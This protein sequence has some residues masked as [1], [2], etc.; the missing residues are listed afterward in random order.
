M[1]RVGARRVGAAMPKQK[2]AIK[3]EDC[4]RV[5]ARAYPGKF[6][7]NNPGGTSLTRE[8]YK[9]KAVQD[10]VASFKDNEKY[11]NTYLAD[12]T[13][14]LVWH[15]RSLKVNYKEAYKLLV[16]TETEKK[17]DDS[18]EED[19]RGGNEEKGVEC[20]EEEFTETD[21]M[22]ETTDMMEIEGEGSDDMIEFED[23]KSDKRVV[24]EF[25]VKRYMGKTDQELFEHDI[26]VPDEVKKSGQYKKRRHNYIEQKVNRYESCQEILETLSQAPPMVQE[27]LKKRLFHLTNQE[28]SA[29]LMVK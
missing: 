19:N 7:R 24:V 15:L 27:A 3:S 14:F 25:V 22:M 20:S 11:E 23:N 6:G 13:K 2:D 12:K 1:R 8:K 5:Q 17:N 21:D 28:K 29:R 16:E 4:P 10:W 26:E 18:E 9:K